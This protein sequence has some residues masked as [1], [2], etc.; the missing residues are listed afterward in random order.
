MKVGVYYRELDLT[1]R[2]EIATQRIPDD[3]SQ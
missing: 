1:E 2:H 3:L